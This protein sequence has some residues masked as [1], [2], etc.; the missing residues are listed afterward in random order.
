MYKAMNSIPTLNLHFMGTVPESFYALSC[1]D[2][3]KER[4]ALPISEALECPLPVTF[5][6]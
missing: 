4:W 2:R 5:R 6:V 1:E 3:L